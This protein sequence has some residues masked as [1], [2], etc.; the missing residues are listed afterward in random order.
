MNRIEK[1]VSFATQKRKQQSLKWFFNATK[2]HYE[3]Y[4]HGTFNVQ[5]S[6]KN[7]FV[8]GL[9]HFLYDAKNADVLP[10]WDAL[11]L[12]FPI[13]VY[14]DSFL[15]INLH[16]L[17]NG[18]RARL[19]DILI[20]NYEKSKNKGKYTERRYLEINYKILQSGKNHELIKPCIKKYLFKHVRSTFIKV[21]YEYW[22]EIAHL[23]S[24]KWVGK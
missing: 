18:L 6:G 5:K 9:F 1:E 16:Y 19:L 8:G 22:N 24:T 20:T 23:P 7:V 2:T 15:G 11:P 17:P 14:G 4:K 21:N 10:Y 13:E 3:D 12:V